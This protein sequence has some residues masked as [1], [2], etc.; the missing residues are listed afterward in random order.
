[1]GIHDA[2]A[3][4]HHDPVKREACVGPIEVAEQA[5]VPEDEILPTGLQP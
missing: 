4:L 5:L 2:V 3:I 1:M